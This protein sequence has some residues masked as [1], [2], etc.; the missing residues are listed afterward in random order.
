MQTPPV[1]VALESIR[2]TAEAW[3]RQPAWNPRVEQQVADGDALLRL[4]AQAGLDQPR[5]RPTPPLPT[6]G[7]GAEVACGCVMAHHL[8]SWRTRMRA[9]AYGLT[10]GVTPRDYPQRERRES[11]ER[12]DHIF[13]FHS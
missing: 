2:R 3:A 5:P 9:F 8:P 1:F 4:L 13:E 11:Q 10:F 7:T 6:S 12:I